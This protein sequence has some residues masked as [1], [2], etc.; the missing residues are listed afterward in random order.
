MEN[1]Q[2][3]VNRLNLLAET[4]QFEELLNQADRFIAEEDAF[5]PFYL[6]KGNALRAL[7]QAEAAIEAYHLAIKKDPNDALARTALGG[8]LFE[9]GDYINA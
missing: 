1:V 9:T 7:G 4:G 8:I 5:A 3:A 2:E 6:F